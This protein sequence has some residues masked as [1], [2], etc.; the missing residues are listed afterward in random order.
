MKNNLVQKVLDWIMVG[1]SYAAVVLTCF[2]VRAAIHGEGDALI[3]A[4]LVFY[5]I[6]FITHFPTYVVTIIS[7]IRAKESLAL[8]NLLIKVA[9]IPFF[10]LNICG[11][12]LVSLYSLKVSFFM[13]V[14]IIAILVCNSYAVM[15]R[16][17]LSNIIYFAKSYM[18]KDLKPTSWS[19]VSVVFSFLFFLDVVGAI[20]L[21]KHER[22]Q[23]PEIAERI[24]EKQRIK[25]T[26]RMNAW[27]KKKHMKLGFYKVSSLVAS[28]VLLVSTLYLFVMVVNALFNSGNGNSTSIDFFAP[29]FDFC[30]VVI[31]VMALFKLIIG[32]VYG[33]NGEDGP[34]NFVLIYKAIDAVPV[35]LLF[36]LAGMF[37]VL[38]STLFVAFILFLPLIFGLWLA[39]IPIVCSVMGVINIGLGVI[40]MI[41]ANFVFL[42]DSL[43]MFFYYTNQRIVMNKKFANYGVVACLVL[44]W[45][46]FANVVAL[47]VLKLLEKNNKLFGDRLFEP[48]A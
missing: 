24:S 31:G 30:A 44:L 32:I 2:G 25:W 36:G 19:F 21:L 8:H 12:A 9:L 3:V 43:T 11:C 34:M 28:L 1:V 29:R 20:I 16:S 7:S 5:G 10:A 42:G 33:K 17:S 37:Y 22:N 13:P 46:P 23:R 45:V 27:N 14:F 4:G 41:F 35:L 6:L 26:K 40:L 48:V 38:G 47:I 15:F 39:V 18:K